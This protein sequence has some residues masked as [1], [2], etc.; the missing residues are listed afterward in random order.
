MH[1]RN[2]LLKENPVTFRKKTDSHFGDRMHP[3]DP[4]STQEQRRPAETGPAAESGLAAETTAL[5]NSQ[6]PVPLP[7]PATAEPWETR[8]VVRAFIG[9]HGLRAGW[10]ITA[11]L[12]I[13][14]LLTALM[15]QIFLAL[16]LLNPKQTGMT[17]RSAL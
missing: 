8:A 4:I 3:D 15:T 12:V 11:F 14:G 10:S 9:P 5:E 7:S 2:G 17:A 13:W 16:H 1:P 6:P